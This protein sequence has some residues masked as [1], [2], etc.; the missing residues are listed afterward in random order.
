MRSTR[1]LAYTLS[2]ACFAVLPTIQHNGAKG[3]QHPLQEPAPVSF[4]EN[5]L[6]PNSANDYCNV[7][8]TH[9]SNI[10]LYS[11]KMCLLASRSN[12][13]YLLR[14]SKH[15]DDS[16]WCI[17]KDSKPSAQQILPLLQGKLYSLVCN[18]RLYIQCV[19]TIGRSLE[20]MSIL[21]RRST[22]H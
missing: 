3:P 15:W 14:L 5:I 2:L 20:R 21:E 13:R 6:S 19:I 9:A 11:T 22:M 8:R 17:S 12:P 1:L 4:V 7:N 10:L 16:K 18:R